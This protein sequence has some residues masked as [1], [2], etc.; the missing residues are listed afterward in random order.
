[1]KDVIKL[2][3]SDDPT[4]SEAFERFIKRKKAKNLSSESINF[5]KNDCKYFFDFLGE[6]VKCSEIDSDIV[7]EYINFLKETKPDLKNV[8][9]NT[10]L[11]ALRT[12]L[13]FCAKENY[14]SKVEI[15]MLECEEKIKPTYTLGELE[16]LIKKPNLKQCAF[17]DYRNWVMICFLM[18]TAVR[19]G[20]L[21]EIK[22][23]DIDF[24]EHEISLKKVKNKK[25]F[26]IPLTHELEKILLEYLEFREGNPEDPLFCTMYGE[27]F[28]KEGVKTAIQRYNNRRGIDKT[29]IHLFRHTFAKD[30]I[31]N[32]G[33][34]FRLQ[35]ILGH[36][37]LEVVKE[38]VNMYSKDLHRDFDKFNLFDNMA[39]N[40]KLTKKTIKM[41]K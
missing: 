36:S 5:Y 31:L 34:I 9:I 7:I 30:W 13:N 27:K 23:E 38:Y 26:K 20:T 12:F 10:Y 33:D 21:V 8:S 25:Q 4:I 3:K 37:S 29:S 19:L 39:H 32:G 35:K 41:K 18:G 40:K 22:I 14:M 11:R 28:S 16:E 17:S 1:M 15:E 2:R 6:D 24:E